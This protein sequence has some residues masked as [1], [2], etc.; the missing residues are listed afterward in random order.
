[1]TAREKLKDDSTGKSSRMT[2]RKKLK[3]DSTAK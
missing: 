1:M 3:D 2:S